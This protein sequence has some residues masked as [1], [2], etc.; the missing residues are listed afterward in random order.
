MRAVYSELLYAT[1]G[2]TGEIT[3]AP[4]DG[5][6]RVLRCLDVYWGGGTSGSPSVH[7]RGSAGQTIVEFHAD[8]QNPTQ[9]IDSHHWQWTGRQV[10]PAGETFG[11]TVDGPPADVSRSGYRLTP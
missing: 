8:E 4:A 6:L 10:I 9:A 11:F 1:A 7:M 2:L 5:F 3:I